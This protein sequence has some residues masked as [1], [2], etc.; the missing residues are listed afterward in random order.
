MSGMFH[1]VTSEIIIPGPAI[2]DVVRPERR[3]SDIVAYQGVI[4]AS[5]HEHVLTAPAL[6]IVVLGP[7]IQKIVSFDHPRHKFIVPVEDIDARSADQDIIAAVAPERV[8]PRSTI[9]IIRGAGD[10]IKLL[11]G[12]R[13]KRTRP[14]RHASDPP[15]W[16][17]LPPQ[18]IVPLSAA[19]DIHAE[20]PH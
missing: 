16:A 20:G 18:L 9:E 15:R 17:V 3:P 8:V 6:Q 2:E 7:A 10:T 1:A 13:D 11:L 5:T 12:H 4:A 19:E 14:I